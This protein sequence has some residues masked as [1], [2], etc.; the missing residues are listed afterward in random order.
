[1]VSAV[2]GR[3]PAS[4]KGEEMARGAS[5]VL[6]GFPRSRRAGEVKWIAPCLVASPEAPG[7]PQPAHASGASLALPGLCLCPSSPSGEQGKDSKA[8]T[9]CTASRPRVCLGSLV[10]GQ[11][12]HAGSVTVTVRSPQQHRCLS[13]LEVRGGGGEWR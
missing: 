9:P 10:S 1:M 5:V 4:F 11:C 6:P 2:S 13:L 8:K 7:N 12:W 3:Q